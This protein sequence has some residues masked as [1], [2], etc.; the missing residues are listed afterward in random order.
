MFITLKIKQLFK[1][2]KLFLFSLISLSAFMTFA[3]SPQG[4]NYQ[5]VVR[6]GNGTPIVNHNISLRISLQSS[7]GSDYYIESKTVT[8]NA[9]GVINHIVGTGN[10]ISGTFSTIPWSTGEV[11]MKVEIDPNGGTSYSQL[12]EPVKLQSVPFALFAGSTTPIDG[13]YGQ[14]LYHNGTTWVASSILISNGTNVGIGTTSPTQQLDVNGNVRLRSSLYDYTNSSGTNNDL[15]LNNGTGIQWKSISES[16]ITSGVG[17]SGQVAMWNSTNTIQGLSNVTWASSLQVASPTTAGTDDPIFEVRNKDGNVVFGVYQG[18]VRIYVEDSQITKGV[19]GGFAIGGLTNQSKG[20]QEYFRITPDSARI[21]IKETPT[22][23]GVRGGF[24]IGGLTNQSK[25]ISSRNLMFVAPDSA[26][27]WV[28]ETVTKGVRGGFAIG[29]L[30]NQSKGATDQYLSLTPDNYFIGQGAGKSISTGLYNSFI[31]YQSGFSNTSGNKNY[32]IGYRSGY[33]NTNG[34]SNIFIGDSAGFTNSSGYHNVYI[35]N[36]SGLSNTTGNR[37]TANGSGALRSNNTGYSNSAFGEWALYSNVSGF[38]NTAIGRLSLFQ[39]I[40]GSIN[41][42]VGAGTLMANTTAINNTA[43]GGACLANLAS[44]NGNTAV[45]SLALQNVTAG[46]NNTALGYNSFQTTDPIVN[47]TALGAN[48][49]VL[50]SNQIILGDINIEFIGGK[51]GWSTMS[52]GRFKNIVKDE[53]KGLDFITRL[54]PVIY[55]F[56]AKKYDEFSLKNL[57]NEKRSEI[58]GSKDYS[59]SMAIKRSGFIAQD[60]EKAAETSGFVF[61]GVHHPSNEIDNY[62]IDYSLLTV[63]LVKAVQELNAKNEDLQKQV[64]ALKAEL[65]EIKALLKK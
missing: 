61:N 45:G 27:I 33:S 60:V 23:K 56:D 63:P 43:V 2:R 39:N 17:T 52:D 26:R 1:M 44:G 30:T 38:Y 55:T 62:S 22:A 20:Q 7:A 9:Q 14:T 18:G 42:A 40:S 25:A 47:S 4:F 13:T 64:D 37:N 21:Y 57:P 65:E 6:D 19:R 31:G 51:V 50:A 59:Q 12:S 54:K 46:I 29:G 35:G 36:Q 28:N 49:Q 24:A 11:M 53:V 8:S 34:Y 5:A 41:T 15:L 10:V 16:G 58:M 3:Q 48:A 32:F